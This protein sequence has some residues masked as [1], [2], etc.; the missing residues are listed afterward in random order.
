VAS[1]PGEGIL[2]QKAQ[3]G[4]L[5]CVCAL[6]HVQLFATLWTVARQAPLSMG[7]SRQDYW[8]GLPFPSP[9]DLPY[10]GLEPTS[11]ASPVL[12]GRFFTTSTR[13]EAGKFKMLRCKSWR[14][15]RKKSKLCVSPGLESRVFSTFND[16]L[17]SIDPS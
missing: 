12:V 4:N 11:L 10:P 6:S 16:S 17:L 5:Q 2:Q 8:S 13:Q 14:K 9:G 15:K 7:F 1:A 3:H